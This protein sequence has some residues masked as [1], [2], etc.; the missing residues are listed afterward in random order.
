MEN[1]KQIQFLTL[2]YSSL[3]GLRT[4]P[5]STLALLTA[6]WVNSQTGPARDLGLPIIMLILS[7]I[8]YYLINLYYN[9]TFGRV[10]QP[11]SYRWVD[12]LTSVVGGAVA[13]AAFIWDTSGKRPFSAVGVVFALTILAGWLRIIWKDRRPVLL[14]FPI[15]AA[16]IAIISLLPLFGLD[17]WYTAIGFQSALVA[18]LGIFGVAGIIIGIVSHFQ[19]LQMLR[20][21]R[22]VQ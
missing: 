9:R 12:L 15:L 6:W 4:L 8:L 3:Q 16:V 22:R 21:V 11:Q 2:N 5:F 10:Q 20:T 1:Y 19:L 18:V 7:F 13:L 17:T 14:I